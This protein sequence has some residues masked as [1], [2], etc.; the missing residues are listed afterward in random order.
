MVGHF[1]SQR[2]PSDKKQ[3]VMD[4]ITHGQW[5][6]NH[7]NDNK[8]NDEESEQYYHYHNDDPSIPNDDYDVDDILDPYTMQKS[9]RKIAKKLSRRL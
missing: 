3:N 6:K 2:K 9:F 7:Y 4:D 5:S 8:D 1:I